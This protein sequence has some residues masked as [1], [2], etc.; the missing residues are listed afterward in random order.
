MMQKNEI[1]RPVAEVF[2]YIL[3][4]IVGIFLLASIIAPASATEETFVLSVSGFQTSEQN[5]PA[6]ASNTG[7]GTTMLLNVNFDTVGTPVTVIYYLNPGSGSTVGG[8]SPFTAKIGSTT[9]GSGTIQSQNGSYLGGAYTQQYI[10]DITSWTPGSFTGAQK[11]NVTWIGGDMP[12]SYPYS[13]G[14]SDAIAPGPITMNYNFALGTNYGRTGKYLVVKGGSASQTI[15]LNNMTPI[16]PLGLYSYSVSKTGISLLRIYSNNMLN[17]TGSTNNA[18][19]SGIGYGSDLMFSMYVPSAATFANSSI[20]LPYYLSESGLPAIPT[21][22]PTPTTTGVPSGYITTYFQ[23]VDGKD[24]G[25][26]Y[27]CNLNLHDEFNNTWTNVTN[28]SDG[29]HKIATHS[30]ATV[31]GYSTASGYAATSRTGLTP[32]DGIYELIM[33][34]SDS[35]CTTPGSCGTVYDPGLGSINLLISVNDGSTGSGISGATVKLVESSGS[36]LY[37]STNQAGVEEFMMTNETTFRIVVEANGYQTASK[38]HTTSAF[39]PDSVRIELTKSYATITPT[40]VITDGSGNV[41][42]TIDTRPASVKDQAMMDKLRDAGPAI[43]DLAILSITAFMLMGILGLFG[44]K[45]N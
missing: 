10:F 11:V 42:Q 29:T 26:I 36:T 25:A 23:C 27:G 37:G 12:A 3:V 18:D 35:V 14:Y 9:V 21:P 1:A 7:S 15:T 30:G 34:P 16:G 6:A 38:M 4:V 2:Y 8:V 33:W 20:K 31:G 28:D 44:V 22:T 39:G 43:L 45:F 13:H 24:N 5:I 17:Y 40:V 32:F 19:V 41:V